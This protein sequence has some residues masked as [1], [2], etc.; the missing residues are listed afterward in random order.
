MIEVFSSLCG[1]RIC[2]DLANYAECNEAF[3]RRFMRLEH[4]SPSHDAFSRLFRMNMPEPFAAALARF[5]SDR[6]QA[7][8]AEGGNQ[9]KQMFS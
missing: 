1:W 9:C 2:V 5:A 4:G 3:L 7:M 8:E 6:A